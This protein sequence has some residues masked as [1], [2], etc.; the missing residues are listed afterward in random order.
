LEE[1]RR[2]DSVVA[3]D[4]RNYGARDKGEQRYGKP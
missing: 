3:G 2:V 1:E 4:V